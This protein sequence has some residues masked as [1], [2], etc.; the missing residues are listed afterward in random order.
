MAVTVILVVQN[1]STEFHC[2]ATRIR[3]RRGN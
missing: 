1:L 2:S 3:K